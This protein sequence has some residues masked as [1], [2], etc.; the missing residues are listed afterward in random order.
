MNFEIKKLKKFFLIF[1]L[2]FSFMNN[3]FSLERFEQEY[4]KSNP[5][6]F[7]EKKIV[8]EFEEEYGSFTNGLKGAGIFV[9]SGVGAFILSSA[10]LKH[11][12][13]DLRVILP[14]LVSIITSFAGAVFFYKWLE[15]QITGKILEDI[16]QEYNSDDGKKYLPEEL[17]STFEEL[18]KEYK[19]YGKIYLEKKCV[20]LMKKIQEKI[21]YKINPK[22]YKKPI[23]IEQS[24]P[25]M[26]WDVGQTVHNV[27]I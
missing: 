18:N 9:A 20:E 21:K 17:H 3:V 11:S 2:F 5:W 6:E 4:Y 8:E 26:V 15:S 25:L 16:L 24:T 22:K 1:I 14:P 12:D 23:K 27:L 19:K 7:I 13:P 10:L